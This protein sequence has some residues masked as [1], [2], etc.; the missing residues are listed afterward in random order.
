MA[1]KRAPGWSSRAADSGEEVAAASSAATR[2]VDLEL[3]GD[4]IGMA[5][6]EVSYN[7]NNCTP[8]RMPSSSTGGQ[9]GS[10]KKQQQCRC[11]RKI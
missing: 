9:T 5:E 10:Y 6:V 4:R 3:A 2:E 8:K 7:I 1:R 11:R